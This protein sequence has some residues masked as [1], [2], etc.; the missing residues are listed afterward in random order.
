LFDALSESPE[1]VRLTQWRAL[2]RAATSPAE[3]ESHLEEARA[4]R[5]ALGLPSDSAAVDM[6][7]IVIA[8]SGAWSNIADGLRAIGGADEKSPR[9]QH[10]AAV[11]ASVESMV[12]ALTRR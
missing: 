12:A 7:E 11:V 8:M 1:L 10:R 9:E 2:E 4:L 3:V 6:L 5:A